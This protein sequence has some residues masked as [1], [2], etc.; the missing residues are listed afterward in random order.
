MI[1]TD[2]ETIQIPIYH[3]TEMIDEESIKAELEND[4]NTLEDNGFIDKLKENDKETHTYLIKQG[5]KIKE[6][7]KKL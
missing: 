2:N 6:Y 5:D 7:K 3:N 1:N 4:L